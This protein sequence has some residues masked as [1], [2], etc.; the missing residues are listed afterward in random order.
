MEY[1]SA[2]CQ[3]FYKPRKKTYAYLTVFQFGLLM[4]IRPLVATGI[5]EHLPYLQSVKDN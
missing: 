5:P 1:Q 4:L 2:D 3:A